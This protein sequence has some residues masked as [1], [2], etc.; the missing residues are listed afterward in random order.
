VSGDQVTRTDGGPPEVA[1]RYRVLFLLAAAELLVMTLW[2]SAS[3]VGPELARAWALS[4]AETAWLTNAVQLGFV[5]GALLSAVLTFA[6]TVTPRYLF[7]ASSAVGVAAT[8]VITVAVQSF[9]PAVVLRFVTG[10][11]LA[12]VYPP[13]IKTIYGLMPLLMLQKVF[14]QNAPTAR[15]RVYTNFNI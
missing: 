2:F 13:G 8:V 11:A 7:A 10:V 3:A 12:G 6:D 9:L 1:R 14:C 15:L 4:A 5:V